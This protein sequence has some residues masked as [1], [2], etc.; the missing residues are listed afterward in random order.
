M[1]IPNSL[2]RTKEH[3]DRGNIIYIESRL[4]D[5]E[6][7]EYNDKNLMIK[8]QSSNGEVAE[9]KYNELDLVVSVLW[10]VDKKLETFEYSFDQNGFII[11]RISSK[12]DTKEWATRDPS[13]K[14]LSYE[15]S[16]GIYI[17][18]KHDP[19]SGDM[20]ITSNVFYSP[21]PNVISSIWFTQYPTKVQ[22]IN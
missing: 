22:I 17:E 6:Q 18:F 20:S 4:D 11:S 15:T 7:Y 10:G 14:I 3:D 16:K 12:F 1:Y 21:Y 13:G 19:N 9:Y 2:I 8:S 5:W